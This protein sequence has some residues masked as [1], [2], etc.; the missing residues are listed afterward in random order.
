M[1]VITVLFLSGP[2]RSQSFV[3]LVVIL[4]DL[5]VA[6]I[7]L[8]WLFEVIFLESDDHLFKG[9]FVLKSIIDYAVQS[10]PADCLAEFVSGV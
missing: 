2:N 8:L 10:M 9:L 6:S 5:D 4:I 7:H 3:I 1:L